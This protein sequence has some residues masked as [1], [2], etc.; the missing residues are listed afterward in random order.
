MAVGAAAAAAGGVLGSD[1]GRGVP[2]ALVL[3]PLFGAVLVL[4]AAA[5][6]EWC[7]ERSFTWAAPV[8]DLN[9]SSYLWHSPLQMAF[10]MG[11]AAGLWPLGVVFNPPFFPLYLAVVCGL[12]WLSFRWI[13]RP[14]QRWVRGRLLPPRAGAAGQPPAA[15]RFGAGP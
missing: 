5:A 3:A 15:G 6:E 2:Q 8:G 11:V 12:S 4:A 7:G 13:E 1:A 10:L 9:Y 14:A